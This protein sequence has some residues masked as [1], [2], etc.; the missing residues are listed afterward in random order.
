MGYD[1]GISHEVHVKSIVCHPLPLTDWAWWICTYI[2]CG[3]VWW[4]LMANLGVFHK[5]S[6]QW[7]SLTNCYRVYNEILASDWLRANLSVKITDKML[8]EM[9]PWS[10]IIFSF[11][12]IFQQKY[13]KPKFML[14]LAFASSGDVITGDSNGN[15]YIWSKGKFLRSLQFIMPEFVL[16]RLIPGPTI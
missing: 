1:S 4:W 16:C 15:I 11:D 13:E 3:V 2:L 6:C 12:I 9:L 14:S 5:P 10:L 8:H 7:F